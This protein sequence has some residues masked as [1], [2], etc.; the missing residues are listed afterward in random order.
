MGKLFEDDDE[1][2]L[3]NSLHEVES[4]PNSQLQQ[5]EL[6]SSAGNF[7]SLKHDKCTKQV[8]LQK[9]TLTYL[10]LFFCGPVSMHFSQSNCFVCGPVFH[11]TDRSTGPPG[12]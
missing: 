4:N 1:E 9:S 8:R 6:A 12:F 10:F 7:W 2:G 5:S 11:D 3:S